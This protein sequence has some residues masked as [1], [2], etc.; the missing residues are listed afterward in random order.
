MKR[1]EELQSPMGQAALGYYQRWM[2]VM[3]RSPPNAAAFMSSRYFRT[4]INFA[5]FV[6]K[7]NL[8]MPEKF[9]WLMN[10]KDYPPTMWTTD[11][12]YTQYLEFVD[13]KTDPMEQVNLSLRTLLNVADD[14]GVDISEVFTVMSPAEVIHQLRIRQ[15]SPWL[16]LHSIKFKLFFRDHMTD[17]QKIILETLINPSY[18]IERF[19]KKPNDVTKIKEYVKELNI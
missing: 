10:E 17:E 8:P 13:H 2:R 4:F 1:F 16:L 19:E 9:I 6:A 5:H 12:A 18:W 3:K 14:R 15:L 7:V 11:D